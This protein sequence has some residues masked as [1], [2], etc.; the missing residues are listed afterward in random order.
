MKTLA[1]LSL[2]T[3]R[4]IP[5]HVGNQVTLNFILWIILGFI[6]A[7][8]VALFSPILTKIGYGLTLKEAAVLV[9]GGL[10]GAVSLSLA[11]LI[12]GNHLIGDRA[13]ETIFLQTTGIVTLTLVINGTTSDRCTSCS[14]S[15]RRTHIGT[16]VSK[17][18]NTPVEMDKFIYKLGNHWFHSNVDM[19]ALVRL[20]PNSSRHTWKTETSLMFT[21]SMMTYLLT[22]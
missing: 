8:V 7:G 14:R 18:A 3:N 11:L 16:C 12:D 2:T 22:P 17:S 4:G 19:D 13:R 15:T 10:R 5:F 9:W 1:V 20:M 6:R 21:A